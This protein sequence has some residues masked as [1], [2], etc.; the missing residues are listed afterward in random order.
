[1]SKP[2]CRDCEAE[3][4]GVV[5]GLCEVEDPVWFDDN[6]NVL[7]ADHGLLRELQWRVLLG[8]E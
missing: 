6:G 4:Y 7:C 1:M 3:P 8:V 5:P 2:I